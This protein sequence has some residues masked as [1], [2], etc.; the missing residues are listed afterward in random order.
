MAW[1]ILKPRGL[2]RWGSNWSLVGLAVL[3]PELGPLVPELLGVAFLENRVLATG[4]LGI[5][6]SL[7]YCPGPEDIWNVDVDDPSVRTSALVALV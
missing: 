2:E 7:S 4:C 6:S 3:L 1:A 5:P